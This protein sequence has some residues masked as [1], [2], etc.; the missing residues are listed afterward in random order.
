MGLLLFIPINLFSILSSVALAGGVCFFISGISILVRKGVLLTVPAS[1]IRDALPGLV[2]I[3]GHAG[4]PHTIPA[5]ITGKACYLYRTTAWRKSEGKSQDWEKILDETLHLPF[6]ISDSTGQLLV[7]PLGADLDL[8]RDFHKEY[9]AALSS[10]AGETIPPRVSAFLMRHGMAPSRHLRIEESLIEPENTL[11][12]AGILSENPGI[13]VRPFSSS[14]PAPNASAP[15][16]QNH[17]DGR[18]PAALND[19]KQ[20]AAQEIIRLSS[21]STPANVQEMSQ[22]GK[23]A[24]A[25][26]RAGITKPEAWSAAGIPYQNVAVAERGDQHK[27]AISS[28]AGPAQNSELQSSDLNVTPSLVLMKDGNNPTFVISYRN[29]KELAHALVWKA[30]GLISAGTLTML[31]G[32]YVMLVQMKLR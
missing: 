11:F 1:M 25:L 20:R 24:A 14:D 26:S 15:D 10:S 27:R 29:Q 31:L 13:Q 17:S 18:N 2:Q 23:I 8:H 12:I 5:P 32:L 16:S 22:Q 21:G 7:E 4:G 6:F 19:S 9:D 28:G 30:A 3:T